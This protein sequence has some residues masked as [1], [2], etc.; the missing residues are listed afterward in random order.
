M[1]SFNICFEVRCVKYGLFG[2]KLCEF[3]FVYVQEYIVYEEVVLGVFG[4]NMDVCL[5]FRVSI[6][7]YIVYVNFFFIEVFY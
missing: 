2:V 1:V 3:F 6:C 4:N 5:V 7:L